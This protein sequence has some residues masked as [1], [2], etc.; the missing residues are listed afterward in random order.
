MLI[1]QVLTGI[2]FI[3]SRELDHQLIS[4]HNIRISR[5]GDIKI[6]QIPLTTTKKRYP[7]GR[8]RMQ[9]ALFHHLAGFSANRPKHS[10]TSAT[11]TSLSL[12]FGT[13]RRATPDIARIHVRVH[14]AVS[15]H[16]RCVSF[17]SALSVTNVYPYVTENP[18][19]RNDFM[20]LGSQI[21][22]T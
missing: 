4:T 18:A 13:L 15:Q 22:T 7:H 21:S 2:R 16:E 6:G 1:Q 11:V 3:W 19:C 5:N 14:E 20:V 8:H 9:I 12:C 10:S 17:T